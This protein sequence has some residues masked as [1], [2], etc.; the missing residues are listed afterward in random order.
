[1]QHGDV[2]RIA[3]LLEG[4]DLLVAGVGEQAEGLV[5]VGRDDDAV[6]AGDLAGD[7]ADLD[8]VPAPGD[9]GD[10]MGRA[11]VLEQPGEPLYVDP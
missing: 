6:H 1:M 4:G 7:V 11:H 9:I 5:G 2:A 10:G 8:A 3:E